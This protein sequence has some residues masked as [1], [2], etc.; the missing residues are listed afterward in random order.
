M[1]PIVTFKL[2][3][4]K[5][6]K[7]EKQTNKQALSLPFGFWNCVNKHNFRTAL[8]SQNV[9]CILCPVVVVV[10]NLYSSHSY[11]FISVFSHLFQSQ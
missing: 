11:Y 1:V 5:S 2:K 3:Q 7:E 9:F 6:L 10:V 8:F 4:L